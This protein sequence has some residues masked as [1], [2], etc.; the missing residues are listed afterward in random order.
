MSEAEREEEME[1]SSVE[2]KK[3]LPMS[4]GVPRVSDR[5]NERTNVRTADQR[6]S[7]NLVTSCRLSSFASCCCS[8]YREEERRECLI[9]SSSLHTFGGSRQ[10][11]VFLMLQTQKCGN[12]FAPYYT[13][14]HTNDFFPRYRSS[15]FF[16]F[17]FIF[18]SL[19]GKIY[20]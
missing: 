9:T 16:F 12:F 7:R 17:F 18:S 5:T 20:F 14:K 3:K 10:P 6:G 8:Q 15:F 13:V 19:G 2:P 4:S 1:I 11:L